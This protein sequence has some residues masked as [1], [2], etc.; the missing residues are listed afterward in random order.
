M[1][2]VKK[3]AYDVWEVKDYVEGG[4]GYRVDPFGRTGIN[5]SKKRR[6]EFKKLYPFIE[7]YRDAKWKGE[8]MGRF[9]ESKFTKK[10]QLE[11]YKALSSAWERNFFDLSDR[12]SELRRLAEDL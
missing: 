12:V 4:G 7:L 8:Y 5:T 10:H 1:G 9:D 3:M 2:K 6:D 11:Y